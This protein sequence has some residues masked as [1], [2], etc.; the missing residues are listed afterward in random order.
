MTQIIRPTLVLDKKVC[1]RNIE[2]MA[3]KAAEH[4]LR[5]RPHFKT[6][7]SAIIGEWFKH[8]G[9]EHITVSSVRMAEYFANNGWND[10]TLAFPVNILEIENINQLA[11]QI[12]LNVLIEN[13]TGAEVLLKKINNPLGVYLKIDAGYHRTGIGTSKISTIQA[14]IEQISKNKKLLFKGFLSHTGN[15][16]HARSVNEIFSRHFDALLKMNTLK[17][18]FLKS[19]P[20]IEISMG[21]TPSATLCTNFKGIDEIRP[22]NFVFYD[23]MQQNLGVCSFDDIAVKLVCPVV[24]KHVSR[25]EIVIYGGVV[26]LSKESV[27]NINGKQMY[28]RISTMK[29][30]N[31]ILLDPLNYVSKLSQEHGILKVTQNQFNN[32]EVGDLVEIIPFHSFLTANLMGHYLTTGGESIEMMPK[33]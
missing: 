22:G 17:Q 29:D 9:V 14:L 10:I 4:G 19:Y 30:G 7:Q 28:G 1:L 11:S 33:H 13:R 8:F 15:T 5:F 21:D 3:N 2:R 32:F 25:N 16:Y 18:K 23:L 31:K 12:K 6:H 20:E 26:H 24:S 27:T